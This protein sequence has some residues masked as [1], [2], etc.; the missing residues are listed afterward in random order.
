[1]PDPFLGAEATA[2]SEADAALILW[3]LQTSDG[4][5]SRAEMASQQGGKKLCEQ[6]K[7][8]EGIESARR[9]W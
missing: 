3:A 7:Q 2:V 5:G 8:R 4:R 9:W 6:V 1:M